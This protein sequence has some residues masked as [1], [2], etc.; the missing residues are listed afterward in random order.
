MKLKVV[1]FLFFLSLSSS[2]VAKPVIECILRGRLGN[3]M[4]EAAAVTSLA[5]DH[6]AVAIFPELKKAKY[7]DIK[8][9][10][11][12]VLWR[13]NPSK[14]KK[15]LP[16]YVYKLHTFKPIPYQSNMS[17]EGWFQSEK[18]FKHN[19]EAILALFSPKEKTLNYLKSKYSSIID[20]PNTVAIHVRCYWPYHPKGLH[21]GKD[22]FPFAGFDYF[23][24]AMEE[25][26]EDSLFVVFSDNIP[27]CKN[28]LRAKN[29]RFIEKEP[30]YH[31]L[32]LMSMCK[33][34]IISNSTFSWWG[35]YLNR[36]P[37][38][39][40]IAPKVWQIKPEDVDRSDL[41]PETWRTL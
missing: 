21:D 9:N 39:V 25:F 6:D 23:R 27:V 1:F 33:H 41:L 30:N 26:P 38:K 2:I 40:V 11:K 24:R 19:K 15:R 8:D 10:Y 34:Q 7:F 5:I 35:A 28:E 18:Y 22:Y 37:E 13:L 20:H 14:T 32:Y 16:R 31:D 29:I 3:Q 17:V 4:F 36:N 12:N